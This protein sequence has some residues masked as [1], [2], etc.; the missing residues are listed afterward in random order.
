MT[1]DTSPKAKE[2]SAEVIQC[3]K[4]LVALYSNELRGVISQGM[5]KALHKDF[6][7]IALESNGALTIQDESML[8]RGKIG[9]MVA[10]EERF[11]KSED[12]RGLLQRYLVCGSNLFASLLECWETIYPKDWE[13]HQELW[14]IK[15]DPII[16]M[17]S[18]GLHTPTQFQ[19]ADEIVKLIETINICLSEIDFIED[20]QEH[21]PRKIVQLLQEIIFEYEAF[22]FIT[23]EV[24]SIEKDPQYVPSGGIPFNRTVTIVNGALETTG[25]GSERPS[26]EAPVT[27]FAY[28]RKNLE[29]TGFSPDLESLQRLVS[30]TVKIT[31]QFPCKFYIDFHEAETGEPNGRLLSLIGAST[32]IQ[33]FTWTS[34]NPCRL[35]VLAEDLLNAEIQLKIEKVNDLLSRVSREI[36]FKG[37]MAADLIDQQ[38]PAPQTT[39]PNPQKSKRRDP[40][41]EELKLIEVINEGYS[42]A[43]LCIELDLRKM[44]PRS[45]W[46]DEM[47]KWPGSYQRA[48]NTKGRAAQYWHRRIITYVQNI[49]RDFPNKIKVTKSPR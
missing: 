42:Q 23:F 43:Q 41:E 13:L 22:T 16:K 9:Q 33:P 3:M 36:N 26:I 25:K 7:S 1:T 28:Y 14:G 48:W 10:M 38:Q 4:R 15:F 29:A 44:K 12:T 17:Q 34:E 11:N 31:R 49:K 39:L 32:D 35:I 46:K 24:P 27:Q 18:G 6:P 40:N 5:G 21:A 45:S 19:F 47:Y 20:N 2:L 37:A 8:I 30:L